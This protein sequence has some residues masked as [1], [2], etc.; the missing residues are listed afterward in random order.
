M[1]SL[2]FTLDASSAVDLGADAR[3]C[4]DPDDVSVGSPA[5]TRRRDHPLLRNPRG[6]HAKEGNSGE[7]DGADRDPT[8]HGLPQRHAE[9]VADRFPDHRDHHVRDPRNNWTCTDRNRNHPRADDNLTV[10]PRGVPHAYVVT[11][12]KARMLCFPH[13]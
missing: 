7:V 4:V 8:H 1:A 12:L 6:H 2:G 11:S 5:A 13:Q 3:V 10:L 9:H